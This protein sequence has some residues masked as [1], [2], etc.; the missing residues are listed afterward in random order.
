MPALLFHKL[1]G[2]DLRNVADADQKLRGDVAGSSGVGGVYDV[3]ALP[4]CN[5]QAA[6]GDDGHM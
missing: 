5:Q 2:A 1:G 3:S 6:A 4:C